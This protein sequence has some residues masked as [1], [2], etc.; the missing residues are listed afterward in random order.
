MSDSTQHEIEKDLR[1]VAQE[2]RNSMDTPTLHPATR[3]ILPDDPLVEV[4]LHVDQLLGLFFRHGLD[5]DAGPAR[6]DFRNV[7]RQNDFKRH[8]VLIVALAGACCPAILPPWLLAAERPAEIHGELKKWHKITL[9]FAGPETSEAA[10][11]NPFTDYRLDVAFK[12]ER[13]QYV[14]PGYYAAGITHDARLITTRGLDRLR[15]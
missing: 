3:E 5:R 1:E 8:G 12:N 11:P 9:D 15:A 14:V 10:T 2:R 7:L 13:S 6:D 4:V